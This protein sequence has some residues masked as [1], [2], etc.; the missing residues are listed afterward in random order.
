MW[1]LEPKRT[2]STL[3][4]ADEPRLRSS[5]TKES[6]YDHFCKGEKL[7]PVGPTAHSVGHA[8]RQ[9]HQDPLPGLLR[10]EGDPE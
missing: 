1:A 10:G 5:N 2:P 4:G 6:G 3:H 7:T 9:G 8:A